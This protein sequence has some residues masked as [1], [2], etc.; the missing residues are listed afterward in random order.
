MNPSASCEHTERACE[1]VD[2]EVSHSVASGAIKSCRIGEIHKRATETAWCMAFQ[3]LLCVGEYTPKEE[4]GTIQYLHKSIPEMFVVI[5]R[6][7]ILIE[8]CVCYSFFMTG[9]VVD[10]FAR[11]CLKNIAVTHF[12]TMLLCHWDTGV[13][14]FS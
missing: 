4:E 14:Q 10:L 2:G 1:N 12:V 9:N 6:Y 5:V 7:C 11:G 8:S 13:F 3:K